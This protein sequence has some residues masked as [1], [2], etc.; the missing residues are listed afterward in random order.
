M[1]NNIFEKMTN[2]LAETIDSSVALA[3]HNKNQEVEVIHLLWALLTNTNSVLNQLLNK[4][5]VNKAAIELEAKSNASKLPSVSSVTKENIKLSRNLLSSLQK[6]EGQMTSNGDKFIAIDTW[7][8]SNFDNQTVKDVLGKYIDLKEAKKELETMRAGKTIDSNSGDDNL[9]ALSKY[10]IDLNKK[11]ID[12]ELDPVIG[13]DEQITRMMQILIRKTKNNPILLGEPGTGKTAIAEGLAQRIV[14][15]DVP[16]SLLNKRVVS[17]DMSAL[18]A[19]AKYRGEFEDRLKSVIDEVKKAGNIILFI[20]EIHTII[21][22]G[23]SEGSMDAANI[24]K[25]SLARGELHTIG[26]TTLKEYRKYFEKDAAM[27]RR[28]QPVKVDEP[29]VNEALQIL[30]GIKERLETHHNVTIND[31]ALVAAAKLSNRYITDRFLPDKAIDLIDEAAAELKMQIESE[32]TALSHIKREIQTLNVEKEAL[33]MEKNKKNEERLIQIE[34][35]LA[36]KN[37]EKQNLEARFENE[38]QTFNAASELKAKIEELKT[39]ANIAKR[40]SKFE[41]AAKI[42]YGEIPALEAKIKENAQKWEQMQKEGTLLRNS[43]DEEAIAS[44]VSR[45]TGIPVNKMMDSEKQKVLKVEEVLKQDVIGQDEAIKAISRAIK[46]NKAGLSETSRPIGSF[47]FLGPTGVGKTESAKTLAK[48]LFDDPKS[49]IRFDMSEYM[50]KHAV[51]R[52]VGAAPGYVGYEEGGQLTEAVRRKPYSVILFDEVEKAHPDVFNILL[53]VLDDGRLTDN[54]GVTV[55]FKNT[56]I[57]L[58]S[59]IGSARIIEISDKEERRKAVLDELKSHFRPEFLNRLDDIV[60]FEQLNLSAITNIVDILF[61]NIKKKVEEKDIKISLTQNAREYIAKIGFDPVYGARPLKRAIYEIVEDKLADLIL[62]DK[63]G[64][65][66][67]IE[68]DVQNDEVI[69]KIS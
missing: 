68:F 18:I 62:E 23:A 56:I 55:D 42:E 34:K 24:L 53:Q 38:K 52:L 29:T 3:L 4:M 48:F 49:L 9:E 60:I 67:S 6:A 45:W 28:F 35:E 47:L 65:G 16:T 46:R 7:L 14:N 50:E 10:G 54:K 44:I 20:D 15:K 13:R 59:N 32:P 5:N 8:V 63:I 22:A 64:E 61:N 33:K 17:L 37:E 43:V 57:I 69:T 40:E 31:S 27:Q 11:A 36:N 12:G 2:Q 1:N 30:R 66:S 51:S 19:G 26:A 39:K 41:E 25:P 58:T 21:G